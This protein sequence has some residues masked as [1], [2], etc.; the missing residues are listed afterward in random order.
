MFCKGERKSIDRLLDGVACFS[1][2]SGLNSKLL[3]STCLFANVEEYVVQVTRSISEFQ[4]GSLPI[5][6]LGL[7]LISGRLHK[8]YRDVLILVFVPELNLRLP[9]SWIWLDIFSY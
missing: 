6:Y 4:L 8:S 7:P 2:M 1:R 3:R 5:K 9:N